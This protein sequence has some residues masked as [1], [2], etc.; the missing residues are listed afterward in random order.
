MRK[1]ADRSEMI[2]VK[3]DSVESSQAAS[4]KSAQGRTVWRTAIA[5]SL[6]CAA[7]LALAHATTDGFQA[8]TLESARR[9]HALRSP[10]PVPDLVLDLAEGDRPRVSEIRGRVLLVDFVYTSCPTLCAALGSVY[11]RLQQRLAPEIAS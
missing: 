1:G 7:G 3:P 2:P 11:A 5:A 4:P 6:I 8:Y 9:L 10:L